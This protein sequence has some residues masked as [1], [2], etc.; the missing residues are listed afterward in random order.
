MGEWVPAG[1]VGCSNTR[2]TGSIR[3]E[4][5]LTL[6]PTGRIR[7]RHW[8]HFPERQFRGQVNCLQRRSER[9]LGDDHRNQYVRQVHAVI[10]AVDTIQCHAM[11]LSYFKCQSWASAMTLALISSSFF[12]SLA[13]TSGSWA[14]KS[15]CC[16]GFLARSNN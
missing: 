3:P 15:V 12:L 10:D 8:Q 4:M 1:V 11:P 14:D 2:L 9:Q 6:R 13:R 16:P 5:Q 7:S